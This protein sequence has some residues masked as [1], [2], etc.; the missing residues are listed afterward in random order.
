VAFTAAG[1]DPDGDALSYA[2]SFGDGT[3]AQGGATAAH[4]YAAPG[5]YTATVAV[6]DPDGSTDT[7]TV[8][9]TVSGGSGPSGDPPAV[10]RLTG[11]ARP[12]IGGFA[13]R[14][15]R[16][17]LRCGEVD[18]EALA[19]VR[20]SGKAARQLGRRTLATRAIA[21]EPDGVVTL[22]VR[23]SKAVRTAIR[24]AGMRKL[25]VTLQVALPDGTVLKKTVSLKRR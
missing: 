21:C 18:G 19:R 4:T 17:T 11:V 13:R 8:T 5:T 12:R 7:A 24:E 6:R 1:S 3:T 20:V 14:G 15:L 9:I 23:P 2:W 10:T 16:M 22:R 25:K